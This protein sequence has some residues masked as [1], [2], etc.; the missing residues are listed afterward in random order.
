MLGKKFWVDKLNFYLWV[1]FER[2]K[3]L[4]KILEKVTND[5]S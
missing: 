2:K 1:Y 5:D 3:R 4:F